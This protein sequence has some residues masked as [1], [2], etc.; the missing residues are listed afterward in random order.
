MAQ[1]LV[2]K[3]SWWSPKKTQV[4][5][6]RANVRGVPLA[7]V[8]SESEVLGFCLK[9][10]RGWATNK[11]FR[12]FGFKTIFYENVLSLCSKLL[13]F[14]NERFV[15]VLQSGLGIVEGRKKLESLWKHYRG[16]S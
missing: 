13:T 12:P 3:R 6:L 8:W 4:H 10:S 2:N 16:G 14:K 5:S 7:N 9:V 15:G 1:R 11:G